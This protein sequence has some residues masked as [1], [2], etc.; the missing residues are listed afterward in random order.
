MLYTKLKTQREKLRRSKGVSVGATPREKSANA[1]PDLI[2]LG[3]DAALIE[4]M[5]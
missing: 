3:A 2:C 4:A 1:L 5:H